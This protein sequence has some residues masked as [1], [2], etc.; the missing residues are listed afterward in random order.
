MKRAL[1]IVLTAVALTGCHSIT[2]Y[3]NFHRGSNPYE[4]KIFYTKYLNPK[5]SPLDARIQRDLDQ[6]RANVGGELRIATLR[7]PSAT[8]L[9]SSAERAGCTL[10]SLPDRLG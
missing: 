6:L 1:T 9:T 3:A 4:G 5:A 8:L 10:R 7:T 2:Q